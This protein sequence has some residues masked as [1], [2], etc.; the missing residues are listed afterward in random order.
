MAKQEQYGFAVTTIILIVVLIGAIGGVAYYVGTQNAGQED[1]YS[2]RDTTGT[3]QKEALDEQNEEADKQA[4]AGEEMNCQ[5]QFTITVPDGWHFGNI[6]N[7]GNCFVST[8][9][10]LPAHGKHTGE[11][12]SFVF[13]ASEVSDDLSE[14]V[15]RYFDERSEG[16]FA[17]TK[18]GQ[19]SIELHNGDEA[20]IAT[21]HGGHNAGGKEKNAYFFYKKGSLGIFTAWDISVTDEKLRDMAE[22]IVKTI[23]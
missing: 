14:W 22:E 2:Q 4:F 6:E 21:T 11:D 7:G 15:D 20:I 13:E 3:E 12:I 17:I 18:T 1:N 9:K 16:E 5:N 10:Q 23:E 19:R 8:K